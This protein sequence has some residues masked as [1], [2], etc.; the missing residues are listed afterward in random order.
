MGLF[1]INGKVALITGG[2]RGIGL[3]IARGFV[4][5]GAKVY[6][7]SRNAEVCE[8]VAT[9]L[10]GRDHAVAIPADLSSMDE[11]RR[12]AGEI[13]EQTT[14]LDIVVNNAGATWGEPLETFSEQGWDKVVD[15]NVKSLFFLTRELAPILASAGTGDD[16]SRVINIASV[17]GIHV[18]DFEAYS[19]SASK[20]AVIHLTRSL[21]K[22]LV[23][24]H[25]NVN[26]IAP[27]LFPSKMTQFIFENLADEVIGRIPMR[28]AGEPGD[29]AGTA[30]FLSAR[31]SNYITGQ[32]IV[33]DGG[34][35]GLL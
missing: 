31:A 28:R 21:A 30:I 27:G 12:L 5:A 2:S 19:Y 17:D 24:E 23:A 14:R 1:D 25:V 29:I 7:S 13:K 3:M 15:L 9:E 4:D 8:Q 35:T 22:R 33:V 20:A 16:P 34:F 26:A 10:G 32:T 6:I 11:V 18:P